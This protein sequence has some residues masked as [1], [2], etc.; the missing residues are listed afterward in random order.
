MGSKNRS[1]KANEELLELI[2]ALRY[3][4]L[5]YEEILEDYREHLA[6]CKEKSIDWDGKDRRDFF[7]ERNRARFRTWDGEERRTY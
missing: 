1:I 4:Q 3:C 5:D 7:L 6:R 2:Q